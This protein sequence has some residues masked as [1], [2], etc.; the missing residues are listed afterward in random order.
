MQLKISTAITHFCQ[1]HTLY[2]QEDVRLVSFFDIATGHCLAKVPH[3]VSGLMEYP[4]GYSSFL[5]ELLLIPI[6]QSYK[7]WTHTAV[8]Q[9]DAER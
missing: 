4:W 8:R 2:V 9:R 1:Q 3:L 7:C 5:R 6:C